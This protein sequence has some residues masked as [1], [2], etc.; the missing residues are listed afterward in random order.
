MLKKKNLF[1]I[2]GT[3]R[4]FGKSFYDLVSQFS[5]NDCI[6]VNRREVKIKTI[7]SIRFDLTK[8][9]TDIFFN[10]LFSTFSFK[11]YGQIFLIC[12]AATISP[13]GPFGTLDSKMC[14]DS[15]HIDIVNYALILNEF[16]RR[17]RFLKNTEK[18]AI[19]ISSGAAVSAQYGLGTYCSCKSALEMLSRCIFMEQQILKQIKIS[20]IRLGVMNTEMQAQI[21]RSSP[22]QFPKVG[23]YKKISIKGQLLVPAYVAERLYTL[24]QRKNFGK[25]PVINLN[26]FL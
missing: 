26:D 2:F 15:F 16:I 5:E 24:I 1:I 25:V 21:R 6:V 8:H 19:L 7:K 18:K 9:V 22:R 17:T 11:K 14:R 3:T 10:Q 4:G 13:I 20:A 12:N 23:E